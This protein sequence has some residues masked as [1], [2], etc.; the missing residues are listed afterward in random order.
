MDTAVMDAVRRVIDPQ[1]IREA[2]AQAVD[3]VCARQPHLP[4]QRRAV[5]R[6]L[7]R[8]KARI[9]NLVGAVAAGKGS[10]ALF[11]A[12]QA[13]EARQKKL[14]EQLEQTD[15]LAGVSSLDAKRVER[16]L[17]ERSQD[18]TRMLGQQ[19]PQTRQL[20]R[21][22]MPDVLVNGKPVPGRIVCTPIDDGRGG[23]M[24]L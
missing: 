2:V 22:L 13:E 20:L 15:R 1:M 7:A 4:D 19:V 14:C 12:L 21:K 11:E 6:E 5:E 23:D 17:L 8:S 18:L 9:E 3:V 24:R 16:H 10:E